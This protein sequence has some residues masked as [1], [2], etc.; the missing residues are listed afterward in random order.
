MEPKKPGHSRV[1][2]AAPR[3]DGESP[4]NAMVGSHPPAALG[5][6]TSPQ[7]LDRLV[8][9]LSTA[10]SDQAA[11][12]RELSAARAELLV[13]HQ[14]AEAARQ[15][16]ERTLEG[17]STFLHAFGHDLRAPFVG[18]DAAAQLL[19]LA[20][21]ETAPHQLA[22]RV[23]R[24]AQSIRQT[25]RFGLTMIGDLFELLRADSGKWQ[26][27]PSDVDVVD[28]VDEVVAIFRPQA[29][30]KG[31]ALEVHVVGGDASERLV[32]WTDCN[33]LRQSLANVIGN[34]VKF[35]N[36]GLVRVDVWTR[37]DDWVEIR[38][39]DRGPGLEEATLSLLFEPFHQS[40]RTAPRSGEGLGL[41]LA[42]AQRA[43]R[44]IGGSWRAANRADRLGAAFTLEFPREMPPSG[45]APPSCALSSP[46]ASSPFRPL[47]VLVIEDAPG[48]AR[49]VVHHLHSIGHVPTVAMS[50]ADA[51]RLLGSDAIHADGAPAAHRFDAIVADANLEG[52][53]E[54]GRLPNSPDVPWIILGDAP[55]AGANLPEGA[56]LLPRFACRDRLREALARRC[57][58][59]APSDGLSN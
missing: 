4:S 53:L 24:D 1:A 16:S 48:A 25:C 23:V 43:A 7:A 42:I 29:A 18:I 27:V 11:L 9:R 6:A 45:E 26:V 12:V 33:R 14:Q 44:A 46:S 5:V 41:G 31:V 21:E 59:P 55:P 35:S 17:L 32:A 40:V 54:L 38:V 30:C 8:E 36:A 51:H 57:S 2:S 10:L 15:R 28:A 56:E 13:R 50:I 37:R 49:L 3:P 19:E 22:G 39:T 58:A 34:A 47:R 20:C 52:G